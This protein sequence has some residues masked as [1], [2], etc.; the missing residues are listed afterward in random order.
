[1]IKTTLE[2]L[3]PNDIKLMTLENTHN[4]QIQIQFLIGQTVFLKTD[5]EQH[6][7]IIT[8]ILLR[9]NNAISYC[10]TFEANESWHYAIEINEERDII[11]ATTN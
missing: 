2:L 8:G 3:P 7:R 5:N 10:L 1:M 11:K 6:A 9:P 4:V